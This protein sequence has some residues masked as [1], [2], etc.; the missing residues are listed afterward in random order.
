MTNTLDTTNSLNTS[1]LDG[2]FE[3]FADC[4]N[5]DAARRI[6][7]FRAD[8]RVQTRLDDLA[9]KANEGQLSDRE[10]T[11]YDAFIEAIDF[12]AILQ[13]KARAILRREPA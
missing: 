4:F 9:A 7:A 13:A 11:E 12:I 10:Q 1:V 5:L 6:A 3:P 2:V 8:E